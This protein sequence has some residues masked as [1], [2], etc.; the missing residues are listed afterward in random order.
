MKHGT[1]R[2]D[3]L[4]PGDRLAGGGVVTDCVAADIPGFVVVSVNDNERRMMRRETL[5]EVNA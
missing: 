5:V 3:L 1:H 2:A 4:L